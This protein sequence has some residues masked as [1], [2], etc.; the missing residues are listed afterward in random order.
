MSEA[1]ETNRRAGAG[2]A[3]GPRLDFTVTRGLV[4]FAI[5]SVVLLLMLLLYAFAPSA[6][7]GQAIVTVVGMWVLSLVVLAAS[8]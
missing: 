6:V 2:R 4:L 8:S 1:D 5:E 3:R 7:L